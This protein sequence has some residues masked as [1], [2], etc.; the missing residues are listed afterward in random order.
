MKTSRLRLEEGRTGYGGSRQSGSKLKTK[1]FLD[2]RT[3]WDH[4]RGREQ[5]SATRNI[6]TGKKLQAPEI[7][8]SLNLNLSGAIVIRMRLMIFWSEPSGVKK[9]FKEK[10]CGAREFRQISLEVHKMHS[11]DYVLAKFFPS[12]YLHWERRKKNCFFRT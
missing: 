8:L 7:D 4:V 6:F 3:Y 11:H 12:S 10:N 9:V 2:L 5:V 1:S